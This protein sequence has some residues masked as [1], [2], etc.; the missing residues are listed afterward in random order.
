MG[1]QRKIDHESRI[2]FFTVTGILDTQEMLE[3]VQETFAQRKADAVYDVVSDHRDVSEPARP[4]QIRAL[5]AE[6]M[7]LGATEGMR[8]GMIVGSDASYGMMRMMAAH[9]EP[10]G[11][12]VGIF[13]DP[14]E[15]RAFVDRRASA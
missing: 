11:I 14:A 9:T 2:V 7:R 13:R 15:A 12:E 10:L 6:L 1:I 4:D 3:A 8:A 5:V